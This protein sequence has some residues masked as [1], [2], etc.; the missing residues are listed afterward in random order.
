MSKYSQIVVFS[1]AGI[2]ASSGLQT[3]RDNGGLW[4]QYPIEEVAT[5]GAWQL[6][7]DR[8]T[9]FYNLRRKQL[10]GVTPNLAHLALVQL[11]RKAKVSVITQNV[12]DLHERVGSTEVIHLNGTLT[13]VRCTGPSPHRTCWGYQPVEPTDRCSCGAP[14]RPDVVW[15]GEEVPAMEVALATLETADE[16]VV[17]GTS[18]QV[19]PAAQLV[20]QRLGEIPIT[21]VDPAPLPTTL[22]GKVNHLMGDAAALLPQWVAEYRPLS[23]R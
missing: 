22:V 8:V 17:I 3:F 6:N 1:G 13:H 4:E 7:P 11:E 23:M 15:F 5:P 2:S 21:L 20:F 12:E 19:Y 9:E 16:L 18:L 14:L 10:E